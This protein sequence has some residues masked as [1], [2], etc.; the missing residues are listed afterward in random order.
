LIKLSI[1]TNVLSNFLRL[2][3]CILRGE[4]VHWQR[5]IKQRGSFGA[6]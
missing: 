6:K 1:N 5:I 2:K 3:I 4:N